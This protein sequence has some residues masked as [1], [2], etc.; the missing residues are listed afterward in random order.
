MTKT[1]KY[2][3]YSPE[4]KREVLKRANSNDVLS[5]KDRLSVSIELAALVQLVAGFGPSSESP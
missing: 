4:F 5:A 3:R 1:K 2:R